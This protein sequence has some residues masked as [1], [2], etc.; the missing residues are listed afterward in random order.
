MNQHI[1]Y[2]SSSRKEQLT[3]KIEDY[4]VDA[5]SY[6]IRFET[7]DFRIIHKI[8]ILPIEFEDPTFEQ[9]KILIFTKF[10][11]VKSVISIELLD[12]CLILK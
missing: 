6:Y 4:W 10:N 9:I 7:F 2:F 11:F 5:N 12:T 8:L 3:L 1:I